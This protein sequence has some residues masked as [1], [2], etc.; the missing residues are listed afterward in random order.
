[1]PNL[2]QVFSEVIRRLARREIKANTRS[3]RRATAQFRRDIA[4]LKRQVAL[5]TRKLAVV[6]QRQP[7]EI[8]APPELVEKARFRAQGVK[9]HRARVGLSAKDYGKLIGVSEMSIYLWES[10]KT[11]PRK[12]LLAKWLAIRGLGKREAL[13]R[14]EPEGAKG[15]SASGKKPSTRRPIRTFKR[16]GAEMILAVLKGKALPAREINAAWRKEGRAATAD[17]TLGQLVKARKLKRTQV[18]GE[19]GSRY[20]IVR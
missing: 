15:P 1:M 6:E 14:L 7:K 20:T 9:A 11:R 19:R 18:K 4:A 3:T 16:T 5:L 13:R 17:T 2:T 12:A 8:A 10:G